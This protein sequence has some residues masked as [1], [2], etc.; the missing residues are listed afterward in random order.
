MVVIRGVYYGGLLGGS[1]R[2]QVGGLSLRVWTLRP[3]G[4]V[5][6]NRRHEAEINFS[7]AALRPRRHVS[8]LD[9]PRLKCRGIGNTHR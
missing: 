7:R 5:V 1:I 3:A 2:G 8:F 9:K 4:S 6:D